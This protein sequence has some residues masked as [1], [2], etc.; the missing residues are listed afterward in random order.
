MYYMLI[1]FIIVVIAVIGAGYI[2]KRKHYQRINELEEKKIKLRERPVI[3]E[4]S[5]V[6]KLK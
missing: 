2:L 3:D 5:K 4:L 1:G 6:K